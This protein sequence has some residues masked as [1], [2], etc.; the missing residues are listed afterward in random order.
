MRADRNRMIYENMESIRKARKLTKVALAEAMGVSPSAVY[1]TKGK[2]TPTIDRLEAFCRAVGCRMGDVLDGIVTPDD[3]EIPDGIRGMW[4]YNLA[5]EV[6]GKSKG[7]EEAE[8]FVRRTYAPGLLEEV[9]KLGDRQELVI[10]LRYRSY[11]TLEDVAKELHVTRERVR[12]IEAKAIRILRSRE[13]LNHWLLVPMER[14]LEAQRE[15]DE[16][17]LKLITLGRT[18][19]LEPEPKLKS[20]GIDEMDLS[21]R[22]YNCLKRAGVNTLED[23][24]KINQ[25]DLMKVRNMGRKSL[26]EIIAKAE[27]YG[28]TIEEG[29]NGT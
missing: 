27:G 22:A 8:A 2:N 20:V 13:S 15:R 25:K 9:E 17:K 14:L 28:I 12:Q 18:E 11:L 29:T 16:L 21:V 6:S 24:Q 23:L 26:E 19:D 7:S 5:E 10:T 1:G 3:Y 4:P